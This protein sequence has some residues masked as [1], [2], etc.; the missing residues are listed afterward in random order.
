MGVTVFHNLNL[1]VFCAA[2]AQVPVIIFS[3]FFIR[4][5]SMR[6][7]KFLTYFSYLRFAFESILATSYGF[8]RCGDVKPDPVTGMFILPSSAA[9][10][11]LTGDANHPFQKVR[12]P[13]MSL[14]VV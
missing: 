2:F 14:K 9:P 5:Q 8:E 6:N 1:A 7:L 13:V 3:G 11:N 10:E 4:L 12:T